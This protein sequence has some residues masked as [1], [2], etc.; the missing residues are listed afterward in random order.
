[1]A[2]DNSLY[3]ALENVYT[4]IHNYLNNT[5]LEAKHSLMIVKHEELA[6]ILEKLDIEAIEEQTVAIDTLHEQLNAIKVIAD[7]LLTD[8]NDT[9][10]SI[11]T[12]VVNGLDE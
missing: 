6:A 10:D 9:S 8:L 5:Q 1:M 3:D 12:K 2:I 11:H 4:K 7:K